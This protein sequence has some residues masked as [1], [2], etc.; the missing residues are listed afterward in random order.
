M[1]QRTSPGRRGNAAWARMLAA[2]AA[3]LG[4]AASALAQ[5]VL[6]RQ[7]IIESLMDAGGSA[8]KTRSIVAEAV[9]PSSPPDSAYA[10]LPLPAVQFEHNSA[11]LTGEAERQLRELGAALNAEAFNQSRFAVRGHTD[12]RGSASYNRDLS[13]RRAESVERH[14]AGI[15]GVSAGRLVLIG[16]GEDM[17]LLGL[18][19]EDP[20]NRRVEVIRLGNLDAAASA[21]ADAMRETEPS[22]AVDARALLV[23]IDGYTTVSS[24]MGAPT[25]DVAAMR[26]FVAQDLGFPPGG[27]RTLL[28]E[29]ATRANIL[30][31]IRDWL[32]LGD[33]AL[34]YF[35][36]HGHQQP[37]QDGDEADGLDETLVPYDV[38]VENRVA[39]GMIVD[40]EISE[41]LAAADGVAIDIVVDAC[42]SGTLTRSLAGP[43]D[44]RFVKSPRTPDGK[45]LRHGGA[46]TR[47]IAAESVGPQPFM[48][49]TSADVRVWSAVRSDQKALVDA[50]SGPR[51]RSVFTSHL[52]S[53]MDGQADFD[54]SGVVS[55]RELEQYVIREAEAFCRSAPYCAGGLTPEVS[56]PDGL[57][58]AQAFAGRGTAPAVRTRSVAALAKDI[59]VSPGARQSEGKGVVDITLRPGPELRVGDTL[60][61]TVESDLSG[62]LVLLDIDAQGRMTQVFPNDWSASTR[63]A[64]GVPARIPDAAAGFRL[65]A[66]PPVGRGTI[67]A[68]VAEGQLPGALTSTHKD[69]S[70][71]ASPEAYVVELAG[72]LR[73]RGVSSWS[74]GELT[75]QVIGQ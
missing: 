14:L 11:R 18:N 49:A 62:S 37:D 59:L 74:Y 33:R 16:V 2:I 30:D 24:L 56:V 50:D 32:V 29:A 54:G 55:S 8:P 44:Y 3:G 28:D 12:S 9:R 75:Y 64:K 58:D 34:L 60:E 39:Q 53:G 38:T 35:S 67:I 57:L 23:G 31:A 13:L 52:L 36:G 19:A 40:D 1:K 46:A 43:G 45:P 66:R 27:I 71:V 22:G 17:P 48:D 70:V 26:R 4:L 7:S 65:R 61:V 41:I 72:Q 42:H 69:L 63:I 25:N 21:Q 15:S 10:A 73:H 47:S 20:R 51:Y 6:D 68:V 5:E